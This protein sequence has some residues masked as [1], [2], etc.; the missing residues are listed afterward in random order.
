MNMTNKNNIVKFNVKI[1][2]DYDA[3]RAWMK[4]SGTKENVIKKIRN[5]WPQIT[6]DE[7][8]GM[9]EDAQ[10]CGRLDMSDFVDYE[11][12]NCADYWIDVTVK[13]CSSHR[14]K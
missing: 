3:R 8:V 1:Y 12:V 6:E 13:N 14:S 10:D 7:V 5:E 4:C 11:H 9:L 2:D